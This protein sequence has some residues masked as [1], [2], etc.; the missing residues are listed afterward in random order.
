M[1]ERLIFR[2][3]STASYILLLRLTQTVRSR[4]SST[5]HSE[6]LWPPEATGFF[7]GPQ[8]EFECVGVTRNSWTCVCRYRNVAGQLVRMVLF[9]ASVKFKYN[10]QLPIVYGIMSIYA[11][12]IGSPVPLHW[13]KWWGSPKQG[14]TRGR[15]ARYASFAPFKLYSFS[16]PG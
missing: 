2:I 13:W 15:T 14:L 9:P 3:D 7:L 10:D 6:V 12:W 1:I 4:I 5:I 11:P 16:W 8:W